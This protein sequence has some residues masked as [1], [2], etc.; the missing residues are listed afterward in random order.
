MTRFVALGDSITLGIGDPIRLEPTPGPPGD[1]ARKGKRAWRGWAVL[2]AESLPEPDLHIVAGNGACWADLERD[3]LPAALQLRPDVASVVIGVNDTLRPNF[4]PDRIGKSAAHIVGA[5]RASGAEVLTMRL[6]D[7]GRMLG[8]PGLLARPLARRAHAVNQVMDDVAERF[9]TLHFDAAG[10]AEVFNPSMWAVD[11]L[12][13]SERG[14]RLIARRFYALLAAAG[15][16]VGTPPGAEPVNEPPTRAEQLAW[17]ATKGTAWVARRSTDLVPS[18]L[19]MAY[20]EWRSG[21][22]A[23]DL[24]ASPAPDLA[25]VA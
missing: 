1:R 20:A 15:R 4:D 5:L 13:P 12:H 3:Q 17:M 10:D 19:A 14:H 2:L 21:G 25:D 16:P 18:L 23:A 7:P 8:V 11:R 24:A 9:G 6:P 22:E